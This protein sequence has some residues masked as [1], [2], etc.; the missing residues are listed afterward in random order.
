MSES[1]RLYA[2]GGHYDSDGHL[3][4]AWDELKRS[5]GPDWDEAVA[6][7]SAIRHQRPGY[8]LYVHPGR[9]P[10]EEAIRIPE[11]EGARQMSLTDACEGGYCG[12]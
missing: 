9:R 6:V 12:L 5:G 3:R 2:P 4:G 1:A 11:D 10:L 8:A 7:D